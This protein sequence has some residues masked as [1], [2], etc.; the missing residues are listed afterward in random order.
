MMYT[1]FEHIQ[2][3]CASSKFKEMHVCVKHVSTSHGAGAASCSGGCPFLTRMHLITTRMYI[4]I[5]LYTSIFLSLSPSIYILLAPA[6]EVQPPVQE[7]LNSTYASP[8]KHKYQVTAGPDQVCVAAP[9]GD[10]D[11]PNKKEWVDTGCNQRLL[12]DMFVHLV[13]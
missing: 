7:A 4:Y 1:A 10:G 11:D 5:Y 9:P 6:M 8:Q 13:G 12:D 3:T 2:K